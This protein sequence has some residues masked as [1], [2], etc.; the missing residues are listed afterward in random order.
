MT[1]ETKYNI[2][3]EVWYKDSEE[4]SHDKI[5]NIHAEIDCLGEKH[6]IYEL[7]NDVKREECELSSTKEDLLK[8]L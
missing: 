8:S 6:V 1:I 7:W 5:S 4:I 3:E 2:D